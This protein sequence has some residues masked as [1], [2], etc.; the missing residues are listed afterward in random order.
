[1]DKKIINT[2]RK[3]STSESDCCCFLIIS[4]KSYLTFDIVR[5]CCSAGGG[6]EHERALTFTL[7]C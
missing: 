2:I 4:H 7:L 1:M 6:G 5:T 3:H